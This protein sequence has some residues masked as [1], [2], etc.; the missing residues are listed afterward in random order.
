M[1]PIALFFLLFSLPCL[2]LADRQNEDAS[3]LTAAEKSSIPIERYAGV[4]FGSLDLDKDNLTE[5]SPSFDVLGGRIGVRAYDILDA[6]L[7]LSRALTSDTQIVE[8]A[9]VTTE[10]DYMLGSY[11]KLGIG[12]TFHPYILLGYNQLSFSANSTHKEAVNVINSIDGD[13]ATGLGIELKITNYGRQVTL[14]LECTDYYDK[15]S[16]HLSGCQFGAIGWF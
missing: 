12:E 13:I 11:L 9:K 4:N 2:S 1:K 10:L 16:V 8:K 15:D 7:R 6:E 3:G 5:L 14:T